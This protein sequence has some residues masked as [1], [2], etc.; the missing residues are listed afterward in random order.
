MNA[1]E[2]LFK[3]KRV[4]I[5][6][7]NNV[8]YFSEDHVRTALLEFADGLEKKSKEFAKLA[9]AEPRFNLRVGNVVRCKDYEKIASEIRNTLQGIKAVK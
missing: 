7:L 1:L 9:I 5:R 4:V 2:R 3:H 6:D 8:V